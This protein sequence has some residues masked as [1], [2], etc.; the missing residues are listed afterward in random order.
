MAVDSRPRPYRRDQPET[1]L[2][3]PRAA[4]PAG[5]LR[6]HGSVGSAARFHAFRPEPPGVGCKHDLHDELRAAFLAERTSVVA[7]RRG[8]I[9][10]ALAGPLRRV[11]PRQSSTHRRCSLVR[12]AP[13]CAFLEG[14]DLQ[15]ILPAKSERPLHALF[16]L[17]LLRLPRR[18]L[19]VRHGP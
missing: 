5:L 2:Y 7:L 4:D 18:R 3:P 15:E 17:Q 19:L 8:T 14:S 16:V 11:H 10:S 1:F 9:L 13:D 12:P 6:I